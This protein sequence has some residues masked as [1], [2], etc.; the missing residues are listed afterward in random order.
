M[1]NR[2]SREKMALIW[3]EKT[4]YEKWLEVEIASL[5][6]WHAKGLF[7]NE[8]IEDAVKNASFS[9]EEIL[10]LELETK[11]DVIAFTRTVS[12]HLHQ[13]AT[14]FHYGLTSTDVVDTANALLHK[15][16]NDLILE[17]L[18]AFQAVLKK[19]AIKY[20]NTPCIGRTHGI[21][22]DITSFGLKWALYYDEFTRH[23]ERFNLSRKEVETGKISGA[24]GNHCN[25]STDIQDFVCNKL[26]INSANIS[27][28]V[29]QRD[30]HA[31]HMQV[32]AGIAT[33]MEKI[34]L[35][36]RHLQK[37]EVREVFEFFAKNQKGSSAM[38]HKKNPISSENIS[39]CARV[40]R[41]YA[42]ASLENNLLWHERDISHSSAERIIIPDAYILLDYM[43]V[44][45]TKVVDSLIV[46]EE[47]M[48]KNIYLTSGVI[49]SQRVLNLLISK[50]YSREK[51][52]DFI[53][54]IAIDC[55]EN[56]LDFKT[57]L[58]ATN[59]FDE[60]ELNE[61]FTVDYFLN[62]VTSIYKRV[63]IID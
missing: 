16:A 52:Y 19:M 7:P 21:H 28:Q 31:F 51:A 12:K 38:P 30:N 22:A 29:L 49:F 47:Q 61:C 14:W 58:F 56:K 59:V 55:F 32:L 35:E 57:A 42:A 25:V 8:I 46:D 9:V 50:N 15:E 23:L 2:Y 41:S 43:L 45:F 48:M 11:H 60:S 53:Q 33:S 24:V 39:G 40:I 37:T 10:E 6:A 5:Y 27:T 3:E 26:G 34:A 36:I 1:I 20:Q 54:P 18:L 13:S 63:K 44:R 17:D 62:E 4:K